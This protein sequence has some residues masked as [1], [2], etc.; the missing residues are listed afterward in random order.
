MIHGFD[1]DAPL[2]C[3]G[4][5]GDGCGGGRFFLVENETLLAYD[6]QTQSKIFLLDGIKNAKSL[7]K[8]TCMLTIECED[9]VIE[10]DLSALKRV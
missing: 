10:F 1:V 5:I 4:I 7:S 8:K 9:E 2:V 6:P 3:E